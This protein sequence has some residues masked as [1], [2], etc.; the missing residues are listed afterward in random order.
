[1][2]FFILITFLLETF[3]GFS[4]NR[5]DLLKEINSYKSDYINNVSFINNKD[6]LTSIINQYFKN[7]E[8]SFLAE[9]DSGVIFYKVLRCNG[10]IQFTEDGTKKNSKKLYRHFYVTVSFIE[11]D[12]H[13]LLKTTDLLSPNYIDAFSYNQAVLSDGT[14]AFNV[15]NTPVYCFDHNGRFQFNPYH[16]KKDVYIHFYGNV[17]PFT[18]ELIN[19]IEVYNAQQKKDDKKLI[20]GRDY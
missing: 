18:N 5:N 1:M 20:A 6:S 3:F 9:S 19:K 16:L 15:T 4:Q 13:L 12:N 14:T 2:R 11:K 10:E 7:Q 17:I 8:F